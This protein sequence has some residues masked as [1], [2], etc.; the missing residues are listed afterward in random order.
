LMYCVSFAICWSREGGGHMA[1]VT[2]S[3]PSVKLPLSA[4]FAR[5]VHG[6]VARLQFNSMAA[7][8]S[9]PSDSVY[10][11]GSSGFT[12]P[13]LW[14][15]DWNSTRRQL[16]PTSS[17]PAAVQFSLALPRSNRISLPLF[18]TDTPSAA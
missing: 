14:S 17:P 5:D 3:G 4:P 7:R 16:E 6:P 12:T 8:P 15:L 1:F 2:A 11:D 18:H 9:G 10:F 13:A